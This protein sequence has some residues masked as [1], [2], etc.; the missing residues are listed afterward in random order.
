[1]V[2]Y[3]DGLLRQVLVDDQSAAVGLSVEA[4]VGDLDTAELLRVN[5]AAGMPARAE[6]GRGDGLKRRG[7]ATSRRRT[8]ATSPQDGAAA[9]SRRIA[10]GRQQLLPA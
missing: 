10:Q 8:V 6:V 9:L 7:R 4:E 5:R 1:L 3:R 2:E